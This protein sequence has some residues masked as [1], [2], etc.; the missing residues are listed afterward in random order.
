MEES[1]S[2][3]RELE[4][5]IWIGWSLHG[6]ATAAWLEGD[7]V[8]ATA[9]YRESL[10]HYWGT[11]DK[12]GI[13]NCLDGLALVAC[14]QRHP[15]QNTAPTE[16]M[17]NAMRGAR[18]LGAVEAIREITHNPRSVAEI[19]WIECAITEARSALGEE[20]FATA[21]AEGHAMTMAQACE[22]AL[23]VE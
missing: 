11:G 5:A 13:A 19:A 14:S 17:R 4:V 3:A 21:W 9:L 2:L 22:Y 7:D 10:H 12:W 8:R 20:T 18:L 23:K 16:D 6:L 1:L 15:V